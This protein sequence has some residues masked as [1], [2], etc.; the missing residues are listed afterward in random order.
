MY[1]RTEERKDIRIDEVTHFSRVNSL[2][3]ST[4]ALVL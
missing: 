2:L 3:F 4:L 1:G